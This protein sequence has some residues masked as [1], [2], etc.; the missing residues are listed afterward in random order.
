MIG[1]PYL[2]ITKKA[3]SS[4]SHNKESPVEIELEFPKHLPVAIKVDNSFFFWKEVIEEELQE[5][6]TLLLIIRASKDGMAANFLIM[7]IREDMGL[8]PTVALK[9]HCCVLGV[10][11]V[12]LSDSDCDSDHGFVMKMSSRPS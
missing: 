6:D 4:I 10:S 5:A 2:F 1:C 8:K 3:F 9:M 12:L 7:I 11:V